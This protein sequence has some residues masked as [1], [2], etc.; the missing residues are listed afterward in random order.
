MQMSRR[1]PHQKRRPR[2]IVPTG[3]KSLQA[4]STTSLAGS[5]FRAN[6]AG[7]GAHDFVAA[8]MRADDVH[9]HVPDHFL[10]PICVGMPIAACVRLAFVRGMARDDIDQFLL[11]RARQIGDRAID[12]LFFHLW[13]L[14]HRQ[15]A[16]AAIG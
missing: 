3:G 6:A 8:A 9:E 15:L 11:S 2:G 4:G 10:H 13:N 1:R 12:R 14:L 7:A 16:L 5:A